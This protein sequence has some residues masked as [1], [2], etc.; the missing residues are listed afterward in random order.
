[1]EEQKNTLPETTSEIEEAVNVALPEEQQAV[2]ANSE[3]ADSVMKER[4]VKQVSS[5]QKAVKVGIQVVLYAF[6][7]FMALIG[8]FPFYFMLISSVKTV[9]E[10]ERTIP[11]MFPETI[12]WGNYAEAFSAANLG[13]LFGNTLYVGLVSTFLSLI[14]TVLSAG[15][16][17]GASVFSTGVSTGEAVVSG[18]GSLTTSG[19]GCVGCVSTAVVS[20]AFVTLL[21]SMRLPP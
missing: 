19:V 11:T 15:V 14:I 1:M 10:Y 7:G 18:V 3:L 5:K 16:S 20:S 2:E 12:V 8:L 6:L 17:A 21:F 13:Q 9:A 4:D